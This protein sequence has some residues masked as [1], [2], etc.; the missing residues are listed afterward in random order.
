[1]AS[2]PASAQRGGGGQGRKKSTKSAEEGPFTPNDEI[3]KPPPTPCLPEN[4]MSKNKQVREGGR[5]PAF[6]S[7]PSQVSC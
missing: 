2:G 7:K 6:P 5:D 1:M 4:K 3:L